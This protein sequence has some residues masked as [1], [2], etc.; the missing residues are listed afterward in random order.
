VKFGVGGLGKEKKFHDSDGVEQEITLT[1]DWKQY[2]L[3][4][5]GRT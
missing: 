2:S 3:D 1:A 4:L 5:K